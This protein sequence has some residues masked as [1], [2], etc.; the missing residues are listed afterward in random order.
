[1]HKGDEVSDVNLWKILMMSWMRSVSL[2]MKRLVRSEKMMSDVVLDED[3]EI[4][5]ADK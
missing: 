1:M 3:C 2:I 4:H 5:L